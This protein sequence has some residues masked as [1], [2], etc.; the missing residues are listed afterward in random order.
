MIQG[1]RSYSCH[2]Y[3]SLS[4]PWRSELGIW[5]QKAI[6]FLF[7]SE[8]HGTFLLWTSFSFYSAYDLAELKN[9][10]KDFLQVASINYN[11]ILDGTVF[12]FLKTAFLTSIPAKLTL[13]KLFRQATFPKL[14]LILKESQ[15][16]VS[17]YLFIYYFSVSIPSWLKACLQ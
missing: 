9:S 4:P 12:A 1:P 15:G 2:T 5:N 14:S 8:D 3:C 11:R 16:E 6:I 17:F 7:I 13:L 10:Y